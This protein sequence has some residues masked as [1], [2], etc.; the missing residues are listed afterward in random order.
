MAYRNRVL[1]PV[2]QA[3]IFLPNWFVRVVRPN[4]ALGDDIVEMHVP[5]DM[6]KKDIRNYLK[7]IYGINV[8]KVHTR[9]VIGQWETR[10][11]NNDLIKKKS[12]DKKIAYVFLGEGTFKFPKMFKDMETKKVEEEEDNPDGQPPPGRNKLGT[13]QWFNE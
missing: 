2:L 6:G 13:Q 7:N 11:H 3:R 12:G 8:A 9:I 4:K 1:N 10:Q 5:L